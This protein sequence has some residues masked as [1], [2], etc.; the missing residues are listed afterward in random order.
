MEIRGRSTGRGQEWGGFRLKK[1]GL[2]SMAFTKTGW[3]AD[4]GYS[5]MPQKT[6][7]QDDLFFLSVLAKTLDSGL[8]VE[9]D[10]EYF[11]ERVAGDIFFIDS[12]LRS[13]CEMLAQNSHLIER[14][15]YLKL[16]ER[17]TRSF[18]ASIERLLAGGYPMSEAYEAYRPQ[19]K[20]ILLGQK[21]LL[22][23]LSEIL[24]STGQG[25]NETDL[26]SS[27]ELSELLRG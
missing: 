17:T 15:E 21:A 12:S 4:Y 3:E 5:T 11:R 23:E 10:P 16:L 20:G 19:F 13:F 24:R 2:D 22:G 8:S 26:V 27:D 9:A 1:Q 6:H 7:Y 14:T 18:S 25:E